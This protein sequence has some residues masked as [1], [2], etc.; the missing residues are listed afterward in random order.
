M[1]AL[2]FTQPDTGRALVAFRGTDLDI[3][4]VSGQADSCADALIAGGT[5]AQLPGYCR[6]FGAG[7]LDYITNA[8]GFALQVEALCELLGPSVQIM[9]TGHSLGA[10]LAVMAA[11]R[12]AG[13]VAVVFAPPPATD[14]LWS[15][16]GLTS[17]EAA[18]AG[19]FV[20]MGNEFDPVYHQAVGQKGVFDNLCVWA[21]HD[22]VPVT[23]AACFKGHPAFL[24]LAN[25]ACGACFGKEHIFGHYFFDLIPTQ[26]RCG[27]AAA[28][29]FPRPH[30][31]VRMGK[32]PTL[33]RAF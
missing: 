7:T 9:F 21:E 26:P 10:T 5:D 27:A 20:F 25:V 28:A 8:V 29:A 30:I 2:L 1:R 16:F 11:A 17:A 19:S 33:D 15:R 22:P 32:A 13:S 14:L 3:S 24:D 12:V 6:R 31:G 18:A 23:C 4:S